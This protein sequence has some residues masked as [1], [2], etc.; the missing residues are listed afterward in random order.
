MSDTRAWKVVTPAV[1]SRRMCCLLST[2]GI[3]IRHAFS[4]NC[5]GV[6]VLWFARETSGERLNASA[7]RDLFSANGGAHMAVSQSSIRVMLGFEGG[8]NNSG[9][10]LS[11][12]P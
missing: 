11:V 5:C 10:A 8:R 1:E 12:S 3:A 2:S 7:P 4:H 6:V 9:T